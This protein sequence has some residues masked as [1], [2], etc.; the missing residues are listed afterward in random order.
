MRF[1]RMQKSSRPDAS[2]FAEL[3][4]SCG[5]NRKDK[6]QVEY[7]R[8]KFAAGIDVFQVILRREG[9]KLLIFILLCVSIIRRLF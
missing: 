5:R 7:N 1:R 8:G 4:I 3:Q 9:R 2:L 6:I